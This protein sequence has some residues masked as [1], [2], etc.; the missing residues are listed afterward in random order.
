VKNRITLFTFFLASLIFLTG[1]APA[2]AIEN[3]DIA[4]GEPV[5]GWF[6]EG[7]QGIICSGALLEPRIVVTAHHCIPNAP[8]Q[9]ESYLSR[10]ILV[11]KPG[12]VINFDGDNLAKVLAIVT[13]KENWSLGLCVN[14]YCDDLD[15][16]AFLIL[17]RDYPVPN[18]L[19]IASIEDVKRFRASQARTITYG[20]GLIGYEKSSSGTPY[21][22]S[23]N[24]REP[25]QGGFGRDSFN[26]S[27]NGIQNT[28]GGDSG[29]P[30]YVLDGE[31][32]YYLGPTAATRRPSCI[33]KPISDNGFFGGTFL[34][35]KVRL[36]TEAQER[37]NQIKAEVELKAKQEA[38]AK[39]AAEKA[40]AEKAAAELKAKQEAEARAAA[41][42]KA[43]QEA[44]AKAAAK[45]AAAK[46]IT[47][48]C[49]KGKTIKKVTAV[50]PK[51]PAGYKK[52]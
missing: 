42:L 40:A 44:E 45:A 27:V 16:L 30:T 4:L 33:Q 41:E 34:A 29:G 25:N 14:G 1:Q 8:E 37:V 39:A 19:K 38:E 12:Q 2:K 51:C 13:K 21:K 32:I 22:L 15:D 7:M 26:I 46:K 47:I 3:G 28:C 6:F 31:F 18:N 9:S 50:N 17:D 43:K 20:Y 48:T 5:V 11:S 49:V 24:L 23:A 36:F 10:K 52:K 35:A